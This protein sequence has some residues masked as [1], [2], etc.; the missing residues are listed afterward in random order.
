MKTFDRKAKMDEMENLDYRGWEFLCSGE[1]L[2]S[3]AFQA[4]VRYKAPPDNQIRTLVLDAEKFDAARQALERAK[5]LAMK[6]ANERGGVGL[7]DS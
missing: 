3:G 1:Q 6:W 4:T 5:E 7:G 2:P